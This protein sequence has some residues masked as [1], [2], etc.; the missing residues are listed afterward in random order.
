MEIRISITHAHT[1][2][3]VEKTIE[4][5][6]RATFEDIEVLHDEYAKATPDSFVNFTWDHPESKHG[7]SFICAQPH[8]MK[9]DEAKM[10]RRLITEKEYYARWYPGL[11]GIL[12]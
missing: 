11:L 10:A 5:T 3:K 1:E 8:N 6:D 2:E 4:V 7:P 9:L 12:D